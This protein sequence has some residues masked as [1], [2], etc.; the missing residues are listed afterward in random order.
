MGIIKRQAV[1][2]TVI[3]FAGVSIGSVS[4]LIMPL[5]LTS[6]QIGVLTYL[7]SLSGFF[8]MVFTFGYN[9][10]LKKVFPEYRDDEKGHSGFLLFGVFL[11]LFGCLLAILTFYSLQGFLLNG[12]EEVPSLTQQFIF[13]VPYLIIFRILFI[14]ID[15]YVRMQFKT[16]IGTFLDGFVGKVILLSALILFHYTFIGF[17]KFI[18]L[19]CLALAL[20]GA[21]IV[22]YSFFITKKIVLPSRK[23][24]NEYPRF[25]VFV[26]FGIL[27]GASGS[28]IQLID[29]FMI[30]KMSDPLEAESLLGV[31]GI[32]FFA[33]SLINIPSRNLRQIA[34]V[35]VAEEWKNLNLKKIN[36][37]YKQSANTLL[38]VGSL[39]FLIGWVCLEP[40]LTFLPPEYVNGIYVFFF[41]GL[42]RVIELGTGIN[43]DIIETSR[44]YKYNTYFNLVLAVLV[45][46]FN[47]VGIYYYGIV[48]AAFGSFLAQTIINFLRG[49]YLYKEF[50][51]W[52]FDLNLFKA[53]SLFLVLLA[54]S[55]F[56]NYEAAPIYQIIINLLG[57]GGVYIIAGY[58][59]NFSENL[60]KVVDRYILRKK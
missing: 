49:Y 31:Y 34:S 43:I 42:G 53:F 60:N 57:F 39:L 1:R 29:T 47:L 4:R 2:S 22:I 19:Y 35:V 55:F 5:I 23:L 32:M 18:Y 27:T 26:L 17:E 59:L 41:L 40:V 38:V 28:I 52:P 48:G 10:I 45:L 14:N 37:I 20:P 11:S 25:R 9:L 36:D 13:L 33:A 50:K 7:S 8:Y 16:I 44:I 51:L 21:V 58:Y 46:I 12:G 6:S 3:N 15:G 54:L 56:L 24:L 30:Y